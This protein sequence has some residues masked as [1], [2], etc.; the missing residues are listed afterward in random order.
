MRS[1]CRVAP[2]RQP[3]KGSRMSGIKSKLTYAN[4]MATIAV[5]IALGG[6]SY[7]AFHL[8]KN[9]VKSKNIVNGQIKQKDVS[10]TL[11]VSGADSATTATHAT[12]ADTATSA[13]NATN[14][15]NAANSAKLGGQAPAAY[16]LAGSE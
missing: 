14:A 9:S 2:R 11:T 7:A 8:P 12:S 5:F 15:S 1:G 13:T 4:V 16:A 6:A 3:G 10:H